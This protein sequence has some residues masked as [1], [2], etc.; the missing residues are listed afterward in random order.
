MPWQNLKKNTDWNKIS[1]KNLYRE[2][3]KSSYK[4]MEKWQ[5]RAKLMKFKSVWRRNIICTYLISIE[6]F[7]LT[8]YHRHR[9]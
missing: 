8:N 4:S 2:N 5:W 1:I 7:N 3:I 9:N 6:I